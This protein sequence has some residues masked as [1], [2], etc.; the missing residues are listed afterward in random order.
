MGGLNDNSGRHEITCLL[1]RMSGQAGPRVTRR[2][3]GQW[4]FQVFWD[5]KQ[6]STYM[7]QGNSDM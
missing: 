6:L 3:F 1:Q 5:R 7:Y 2:L 4:T